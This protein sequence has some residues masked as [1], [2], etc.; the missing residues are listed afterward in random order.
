MANHKS[1]LKRIRQTE[2]RRLRNRYYAKTAR[3]A[4]R[5]LR[6]LTDKAEAEA[7]YRKVSAM[8]DRLAS[9]KSISKNKAANLKSKLAHH[10]AKLAA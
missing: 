8:L 9:K 3:N 4:V 10:I 6:K 7:A 1:S 5:N 2:S